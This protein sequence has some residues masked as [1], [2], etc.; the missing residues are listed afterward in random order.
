MGWFTCG[1]TNNLKIRIGQSPKKDVKARHPP[2]LVTSSDCNGGNRT[3]SK[4]ILHLS[5]QIHLLKMQP[6]LTIPR[7]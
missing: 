1:T 4:N 6:K 5:T 3:P 2:L 7:S